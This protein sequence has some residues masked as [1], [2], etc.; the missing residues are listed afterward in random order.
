M[1]KSTGS[2]AAE[3]FTDADCQEANAE[4]RDALGRFTHGNVGGPG[5]PFARRVARLR[6]VLLDCVTEEDMQI[7]A[8]Q[9]VVQ[10]KLGDQAAMKLLFQYVVGRPAAVVDPDALDQQEVELYQRNPAVGALREVLHGRMAADVACGLLRGVLPCLAQRD[11]DLIAEAMLAP[12]PQ[13]DEEDFDFEDDLDD[14]DDSDEELVE[15][16]PAAGAGA[17]PGAQ[18]SS[19]GDVN[20]AR[21]ADGGAPSTNG[22]PGADE[23]RRKTKAPPRGGDGRAKAAG[24]GRAKHGA[25]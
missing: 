14:E 19:N 11:A 12:A 6:Q 21:G 1:K 4:G 13:A 9:L 24:N 3:S 16:A 7:I 17:A 18:A 23:C 22:D 2:Q 20:A 25:S 5:N 15:S 10:A 8:G